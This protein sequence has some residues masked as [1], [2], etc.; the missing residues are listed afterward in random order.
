MSRR[1]GAKTTIILDG[2]EDNKFVVNK[3]DAVLVH[4][5]M[6]GRIERTDIGMR[7]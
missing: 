2:L 3:G 6:V 5:I 7:E 1:S 4:I